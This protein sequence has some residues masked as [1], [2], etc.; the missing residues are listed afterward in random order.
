MSPERAGK[1]A[2]VDG[3][4]E[5]ATAPDPLQAPLPDPFDALPDAVVS[6]VFKALGYQNSWP[7]RRV[8]RR[9]RRVVE[10]TEWAGVE[11]TIWGSSG[12]D[13][14]GEQTRR[15][16]SA[17]SVFENRKLRLAKGVALRARLPFDRTQPE[18]EDNED[19][20]A[21]GLPPPP[22]RTKTKWTAE[23]GANRRTVGAACSLLAAIARSHSGP[24]ELLDVFVGLDGVGPGDLSD[25]RFLNSYLL[26]VLGALAP[27]GG[28]PSAL[29]ILSVGLNGVQLDDPGSL[30]CPTWPPAAELRA[31]LAPFG[32][33]LSLTLVFDQSCLGV[34]PQAAAAIAE[35][36]PLL[37]HV[38]LC[39]SF[40]DKAPDGVL[41]SL[42]R[43]A[44]LAHL[45]V[46]WPSASSWPW[47]GGHDEAKVLDGGVVALATGPAGQSLR[48]LAFHTSIYGY[49]DLDESW[50]PYTWLR[51]ADVELSG[52]ALAALGGMP[53][54]EYLEPLQLS[55]LFLNPDHVTPKAVLALGRV[56]G[57]R[58]ASVVVREPV[59]YSDDPAGR[60]A[61]LAG[62]LGALGQALSE[63]PSVERL[64]LKLELRGYVD[65][66]HTEEDRDQFE[67]ARAALGPGA[68]AALL[69]SA[70]VQRSLVFLL[71]HAAH[72]MTEAE[73]EAVVALGA[74]ERLQLEYELE[75]EQTDSLRP[76]EIL[77]GLHPNVRACVNASSGHRLGSNESPEGMGVRELEA[78]WTRR[79][80]RCAPWR[81]LR[82]GR[83]RHGWVFA[84][85]YKNV[86]AALQACA[87]FAWE[88][89]IPLVGAPD[90]KSPAGRD[91]SIRLADSY[92]A[93][94]SV[95]DEDP[96]SRTPAHSR[97]LSA[98][99]PLADAY[100]G[101]ILN[102]LAF[103]ASFTLDTQARV[104]P[105]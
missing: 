1:R 53:L 32:K 86:D 56:P 35:A 5:T 19:W 90:T 65:F 74:L 80:G 101:G 31:A 99:G 75:P 15:F 63:A 40:E 28:A 72:K 42:S 22:P 21:V 69:G 100:F 78:R 29:Q 48:G 23:K 104:P 57:L 12:E 6:D 44:H 62:L 68:V 59:G 95:L 82:A 45:I 84:D 89:L 39:P 46:H 36:C 34:S 17:L 37:E 26:G 61:A 16:R 67:R 49:R 66:Y 76:Y 20:E 4:A 54:L 79:S 85:G 43:L 103:V 105:G 9:W 58:E 38:C 14:D 33:L 73:A 7:L 3:A 97:A 41:A 27:P 77:L 10:E 64:T 52:G 51:L 88:R 11:L 92:R 25:P 102:A 60:A 24:A 93:S 94:V 8:C 83:Q 30:R 91:R 55:G 47:D 87:R 71:L 96:S 81:L 98:V 50:D 2:R 18:P 13:R 70:G